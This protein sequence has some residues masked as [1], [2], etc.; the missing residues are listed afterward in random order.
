M[1]SII[2]KDIKKIK[3]TFEIFSFAKL[4]N[5]ENKEIFLNW[6]KIRLIISKQ[7]LSLVNFKK[8]FDFNSL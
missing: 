2:I 1:P 3:S 8:L 6:G 5:F 7:S 4:F